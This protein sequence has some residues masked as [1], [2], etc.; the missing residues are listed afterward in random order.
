MPPSTR[1]HRSLPSLRPNLICFSSLPSTEELQDETQNSSCDPTSS[2]AFRVL[3]ISYRA[4]PRL[5]TEIAVSQVICR[6]SA[7]ECVTSM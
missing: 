5:F 3:W 1:A 7:K 4:P 2:D 6:L